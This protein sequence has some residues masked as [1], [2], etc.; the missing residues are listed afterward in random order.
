[1]YQARTYMCFGSFVMPWAKHVLGGRDLVRR[2]FDA[3][4]RIGDLTFASYCCCALI[5]DVLTMGDPVAEVQPE[6]EA[7][8][9]FVRRASFV[10]I[11]DS[12]IAQVGLIRTL[13]GLTPKFGCFNDEA[14]DECGFEEHLA[15]NAALTAA[16]FVYSALKVQARFHAMDYA[17]AVDTSWKAQQL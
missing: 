15:K 3:A 17:S 7:G 14:F 12:A 9:A 16:E 11:V 13:R 8:L 4:Y 6:A 2:A 5:T 10:L 1:R